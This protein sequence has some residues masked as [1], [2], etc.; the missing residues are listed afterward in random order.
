MSDN[1]MEDA[2]TEITGMAKQGVRHPSTKPV[3][4]AAAIGAVVGWPLPLLSPIAGAVIGAGI[5]FYKRLRP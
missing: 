5:M 3:L 2:K 4:A 1:I